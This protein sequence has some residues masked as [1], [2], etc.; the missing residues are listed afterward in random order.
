MTIFGVSLWRFL[1]GVFVSEAVPILLLVLAMAVV[2]HL[3]I[4]GK[5]SPETAEAYGAWIGPIGGALATAV[6]AWY[7]ARSSSSPVK[8]GIALGVAVAVLDLGLTLLAAKGQPF[9]LLFAVSVLSRIAGGW[10]GGL[11]VARSAVPDA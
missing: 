11:L 9:R 10:L 6:V 2:G 8:V 7:I 4:G 5:P 1:L 3:I